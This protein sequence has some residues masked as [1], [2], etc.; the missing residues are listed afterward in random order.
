VRRLWRE[1]ADRIEQSQAI[2]DMF[3]MYPL[4]PA[5]SLP[6]QVAKNPWAWMIE[7]NGLLVD[8]RDLPREIQEV[9]YAKGLIPYIPDEGSLDSR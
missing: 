1:P 8:V 2:R 9:A 7:F 6:S 3:H 5:W 4:D